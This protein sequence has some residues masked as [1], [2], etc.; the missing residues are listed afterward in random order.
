MR[1]VRSTNIPAQLRDS[2]AAAA[3]A[4]SRY[5]S[6]RAWRQRDPE[7]WALEQLTDS[8]AAAEALDAYWRDNGYGHASNVAVAIAI[9]AGNATRQDSAA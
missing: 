7:R 1:N 9:G 3:R 6:S 5:F 8:T 4:L 2:S